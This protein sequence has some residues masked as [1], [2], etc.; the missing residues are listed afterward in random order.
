M[1][2]H[3]K[4]EKYWNISYFKDPENQKKWAAIVSLKNKEENCEEPDEKLGQG[5]SSTKLGASKR[6]A[7]EA[8]KKWGIDS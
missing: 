8:L 7:R 4:K 1:S 3:T 6:A 2:R 5:T